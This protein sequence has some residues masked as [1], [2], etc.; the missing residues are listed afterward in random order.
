MYR[1]EL[2]EPGLILWRNREQID[3]NPMTFDPFD[4]GQVNGDV[5][6]LVR[7]PETNLDIISGSELVWG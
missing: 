5:S 4:F 6:I 3:L 7:Q 1:F 2:I